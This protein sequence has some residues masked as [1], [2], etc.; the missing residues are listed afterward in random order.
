MAE[1]T[2]FDPEQGADQPA[3][4]SSLMEEDCGEQ[5]NGE[6]YSDPEVL[7]GVLNSIMSHYF[8]YEHSDGTTLNIAD[9]LLLIRQ[10]IDKNTEVQQ[11]LLE[12]LRPGVPPSAALATKP[13]G[14]SSAKRTQI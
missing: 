11:Q 6:G 4:D 3:E 7:G 2:N 10:S 8:E 13:K 12:T 14:A 1:P 5:F 9:I